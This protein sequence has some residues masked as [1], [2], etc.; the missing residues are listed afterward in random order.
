MQVKQ[1]KAPAELGAEGRRPWREIVADA[2]GQGIELTAQELVWLRQAGKLAD[3][4]GLM[5]AAV[6]GAE[7]VVPGYNRQ[8]TAHPFLCELRMTRQLLAQTVARIDLDVPEASGV[9]SG[10]G[11]NR[12]RAAAL[13]R[14][15]RGA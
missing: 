13:A 5:E 10:A 8:P 6:A 4:I 12:F 9:S 3:T 2:A 15:N 14:W 11:G 1:P 7:L